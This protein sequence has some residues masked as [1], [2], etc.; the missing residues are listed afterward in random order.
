M[1]DIHDNMAPIELPFFTG[2]DYVF[3]VIFIFGIIGFIFFLLKRRKRL[4]RQEVGVGDY[5]IPELEKIKFYN[6][7]KELTR[8]RILLKEEEW[9]VF[10]HEATDLLKLYL[11]EKYKKNISEKTTSEVLYIVK[12]KKNY[13]EVGDFF[14]VVDLVK[15]AGQEGEREEMERIFGILKGI[16][17]V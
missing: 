5:D 6:W 12:N 2:W 3:L 1:K 11:T 8:L 10:V 14:Q 13:D 15:F 7:S 4:L 9:K 16:V 17:G